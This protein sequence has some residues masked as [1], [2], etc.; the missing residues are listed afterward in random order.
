[1]NRFILIF[2]G[3]VVSN[4][5]IGASA[6]PQL[7]AVPK[8]DPK[9]HSAATYTGIVANRATNT[10][11]TQKMYAHLAKKS[12]QPQAPANQPASS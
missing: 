8:Q 1:M 12:S 3:I 11:P 10:N 6:Q 5:L 7:L 2:S 4:T 9:M